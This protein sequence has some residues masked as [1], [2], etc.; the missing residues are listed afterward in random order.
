MDEEL[1]IDALT[2]ELYC[3]ATQLLFGLSVQPLI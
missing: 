1:F 2:T 3:A